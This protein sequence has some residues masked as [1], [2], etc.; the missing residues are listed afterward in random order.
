MRKQIKQVGLFQKQ[1]KIVT[2]EKQP[3]KN[4]LDGIQV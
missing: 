3:M 1:V 4:Q 2:L